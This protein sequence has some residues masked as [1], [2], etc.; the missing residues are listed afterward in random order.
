[1]TAFET[2]TSVGYAFIKPIFELFTNRGVPV[3]I[4][5]AF[6]VALVLASLLFI[7][8]TERPRRQIKHAVSIL[9]RLGDQ[10]EFTATLHHVQEIMRRL[11]SAP[12]VARVRGDADQTRT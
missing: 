4:S 11:G 6:L 12:C 3:A 9:G 7:W 10:G 2:F 5:L 1:M 8:V